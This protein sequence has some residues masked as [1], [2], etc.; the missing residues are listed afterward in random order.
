MPP[1]SKEY[2]KEWYDK[3]KDKHNKYMSTQIECE[4]GRIIS[5][6]SKKAHLETAMHK[7]LLEKIQKEKDVIRNS[8]LKEVLNIKQAIVDIEG[9]TP[10]EKIL[11]DNKKLAEMKKIL[12][13]VDTEEKPLDPELTETET[14]SETKEY[15]CEKCGFKGTDSI[16]YR[17]HFAT[18]K[19]KFAKSLFD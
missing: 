5:R 7:R 10:T 14:K 16:K 12:D 2:N 19:H 6:N 13:K 11:F 17:N 4:C 18:S 9:M 8:V 3:N 15:N 1:N